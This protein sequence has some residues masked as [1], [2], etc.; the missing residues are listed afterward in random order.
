MLNRFVTAV[1][2]CLSVAL[3]AHAAQTL[4][5]EGLVSPAWVERANGQRDPLSVGMALADK[6]RI[7][8]GNGARALLRL[9]DGSAIK[10]GENALL[11]VDD[12][13]Q[14]SGV[15]A[16]QLVTASLDVARGAFRFTTNVFA[17]QRSERDVKIRITTVTAGIRGTDVWGKS[18]DDRDVVCL[19]EGKIAVNHAGKDFT[20]DQPLQF[21]IAPRKGE[22]KPVA[23]VDKKQLQEWAAETEI[24]DG[25]GAAKRGGK[26]RVEVST[27]TDQKSALQDYDALRKAGYPAE[28]RPVKTDAGEEF[29]VRILNLP[30][31]KDAKAL[32]DRLNT[33]GFQEAKTGR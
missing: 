17:R 19:I 20:M 25:S 8:T 24:Q 23:P 2:L 33:L 29:R 26:F 14:K 27:R 28:I 15:T 21:F 7:H 1:L 3:P 16:K 22:P 12:L 13:A 18:S 32:I 4:T 30:G 10:L 31:L 9:A 11:A 6:E 5:V